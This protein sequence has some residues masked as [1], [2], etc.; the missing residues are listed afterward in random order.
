M[1]IEPRNVINSPLGLK[2]AYL[3]GK[4]TPFGLGH[5]IALFAA[6]RISSRKDW[7]LVQ[8]VRCNQWVI[9]RDDPE[10]PDLDRLVTE[11]FRSTAISIFDFYHTIN[12]P[13]ESLRLI[14]PHPVA[15]QLVQR[16][17]YDTRG[18]IVVG[19][20]MSNFDMVFQL[21]GLAGVKAMVITLQELN[22]AYQKQYEMRKKSGLE[23]VPA[24][25]GSVKNAIEY[26][27]AGGLVIS[28]M[29]RP[30]ETSSYRPNF[31]G[32]PA[33][34]PIHHVFLALKAQVPI[35]VAAIL[36]LA[37][38]KY[39]FLFSEPIEMQPHPNRHQETELN[40]ERV[41]QVAE[42]FIRQDSSQWS[43]T[44]PLWPDVMSQVPG[45]HQ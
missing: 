31:F 45:L 13:G 12:S 27:R 39:N 42:G 32:L 44:F 26:L 33:A 30:D 11:N 43:M 20:H 40:A 10:K 17:K 6:D 16:P 29:D 3:L 21:G 38:G 23:I 36:K 9:H 14:E 4:Y 2:F 41:L 18:L 7:K 22:P 35:I 37:D 1:P 25:F 19:I 34:M 15:I 28:A 8:A 24:S 5:R